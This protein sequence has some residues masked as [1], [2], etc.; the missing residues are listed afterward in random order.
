MY[1]ARVRGRPVLW[2]LLALCACPGREGDAPSAARVC[3]AACE[4]FEGC[5]DDP[6]GFDHARCVHDCQSS[7]A[8][9][10]ARNPGLGC[11]D[12]SLE[13]AQCQAALSCDDLERRA[14]APDAPE[15]P[16]REFD[17]ELEACARE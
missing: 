12:A 10:D 2:S 17:A 1:P 4:N 5:A 8:S 9:L 6:A 16:C 7:A 11:G 14:A 13:L 3:P 15:R